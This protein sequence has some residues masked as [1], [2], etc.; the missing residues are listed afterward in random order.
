MKKNIPATLVM[1]GLALA[2]IEE[3]T[4]K[5]GVGGV[6]FGTSGYLK[7]IDAMLPAWTVPGTKTLSV[8]YPNGYPVRLDG[9][10]MGIGAGMLL[11]DKVA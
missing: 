10:L 11:Y 9:Y 8:R 6:L 4:Y 5:S 7:G 3:L 1:V 2:V